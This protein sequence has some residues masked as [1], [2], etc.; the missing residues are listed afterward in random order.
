MYPLAAALLPHPPVLIPEIG[1]KEALIAEKT[2]KG[3]AEVARRIGCLQPE[4]L[5]LISP[6]GNLFRDACCILDAPVLRG[7][8]SSFGAR[9]LSFEY[10]TDHLLLEKLREETKDFPVLFLDEKAARKLGS[11]ELDH[12]ATVPL[13]FLEKSWQKKPKLLHINYGLLKPSELAYF[14]GLLRRSIRLS[15]RRVVVLASGDL[16]HRLKAEG[17]YTY[18]EEGARFD[19]QIRSIIEEGKL[20]AFFDID[21]DWVEKAGECGLRS[22]QILAGVLD[23]LPLVSECISYEGPWGVGYMSA[24][25]EVEEEKDKLLLL[26][27]EALKSRLVDKKNLE[28]PPAFEEL[29]HQKKGCFVSL[30]KFG[31]LRG[32]IGTIEPTKD[33]LALEI[34][35]NAQSA[36]LEDSRFPPVQK[37]ELEDL[38]ISVD[39]LNPIEACAFEDLDPKNYGVIVKKGYR[40]GLLLPDLPGIDTPEQQVAIAKNKAMIRPEE[41][42]EFFRFK[43]IRH[44]HSS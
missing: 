18:H 12:G 3:M 36:A 2:S 11:L 38:A 44:G 14:G 41:E 21:E 8:L 5:V 43:V 39:E 25:M 35:A 37:D 26:A 24:F 9:E 15:G 27:K 4:T 40:R 13:Y 29:T 31:R 30:H 33:N 10:E 28:L 34:I 16:S 7:N 6:H 23:G 1:G 19:A 20:N 32:C 17:P 42:V 22:L